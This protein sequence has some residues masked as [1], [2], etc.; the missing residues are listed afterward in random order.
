METI[1]ELAFGRSHFSEIRVPRKNFQS[2]HGLFRT[3]CFPKHVRHADRQQKS[4]SFGLLNSRNPG[5]NSCGWESCVCSHPELE[6]ISDSFPHMLITFRSSAIVWMFVFLQ[7]S[8]AEL[9]TPKVIVLGAGA[10]N[11][12]SVRVGGLHDG[13]S[14]LI[15]EA[16]KSF[17]ALSAMW[18]LSRRMAI[19][20]P[21]SRLSPDTRSSNTL[22][23]DFF[24]CRSGRNKYLMF[25]SNLCETHCLKIFDMWLPSHSFFLTWFI[26]PHMLS[27]LSFVEATLTST[28]IWEI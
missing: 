8:C 22:I 16:P 25:K 4:Q 20:H 21:G 1:C 13:I 9:L 17:L 11:R 24:A 2:S 7:N 28:C 5:I 27:F 19:Y 14:A 12:Y 15:K 6:S 18:K 10:Y 26:C 3:T 23:M